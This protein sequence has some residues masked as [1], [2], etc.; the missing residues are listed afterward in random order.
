MKL[1]HGVI[2]FC[3][4]SASAGSPSAEPERTVIAGVRIIDG[5]GAQPIDDAVV[6]VEGDR[7]RAAGPHA[8]VQIPAGAVIVDA[9]GQL[10]LPGLVDV[11][12]HINQPAEEMKRY[13]RAQLQ[14]GVTTMRSA[15]NDKPETVPLFRQT[16]SG[17]ILGPRAYTAGQG[18]NLTGPYP[19]APTFKPGTPDEARVN[20]RS[21]KRQQV[22]FLKI[23]MT[24]PMFPPEIIAAIVG[25]ART[26]RIPVI[27]HVTDVASLHQLAD[28]GVTDFLHTPVDQP[29]TQDL[30]AYARR[31][32]LTFAPTL[33]NIES[34]WFYYEHPEI[35]TM[36]TLQAALYPRGRQMLADA[37]RRRQT[38]S[39]SDLSERKARMR[40]QNYP[41][42]KAMSA[43]GVRVVTG[44]DCGAEASQVTPFGHATHREIQMF[45]E[46]GMSPLAAIRAA[47]LDAARVI[48]RMEDPEYGSVRA[49]KIADLLLLDADP[50]VDIH[51]TIRIARVMRAGHWIQMSG[52]PA[53]LAG[54]KTD[55]QVNWLISR[56]NIATPL[57]RPTTTSEF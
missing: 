39:A 41:F 26:E 32:K 30:I 43:A 37:E 49:G 31:K 21:L 10:L 6:V 3:L 2:L 51:N 40:D 15:G 50:T 52:S 20:V 27:A 8:R 34:R 38:L 9:K 55:R 36:P 48:T 4:V 33:A 45:V 19:G 28:L 46:A 25:E 1:A 14:W 16:R 17:E 53:G 29:L 18:F 24:P 5:T 12:C 56:V 35:L 7:I 57:R 47:T 23:W 54:R 13:W 44:T 42:I 11:H 22:D